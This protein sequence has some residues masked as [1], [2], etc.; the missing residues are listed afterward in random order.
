M[1]QIFSHALPKS[2]VP[3][4]IDRDKDRDMRSSRDGISDTSTA[5]PLPCH[6]GYSLVWHPS[7]HVPEMPRAHMV[8]INAAQRSSTPPSFLLSRLGF[9]RPYH[10]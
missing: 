6:D 4:K 1:R 2:G 8:E 5:R 10:L 3:C 7:E 9:R